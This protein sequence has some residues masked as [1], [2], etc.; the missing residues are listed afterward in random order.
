ML[1]HDSFISFQAKGATEKKF[2][3]SKKL[4][5]FDKAPSVSTYAT[6]YDQKNK[7]TG[8][9]LFDFDSVVESVVSRKSYK[10]V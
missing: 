3:K 7:K 5:K 4:K 1:C 9:S 6:D 10:S 8:S 2:G